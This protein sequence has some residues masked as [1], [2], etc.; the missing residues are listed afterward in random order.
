[1]VGL[2]VLS[3]DFQMGN[4]EIE[5]HI[6]TIDKNFSKDPDLTATSLEVH[7]S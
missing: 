4:P 2:V 5:S 7:F 1:M 6:E 3:L